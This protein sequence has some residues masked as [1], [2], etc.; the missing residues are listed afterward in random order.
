M[1]QSNDRAAD[2]MEGCPATLFVLS[3]T[4]DWVNRGIVNVSVMSVNRLG[5]SDVVL[6]SRVDSQSR[7]EKPEETLIVWSENGSSKKND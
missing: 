2:D 6:E 1:Y 7:Y 4:G 5:G 3:A